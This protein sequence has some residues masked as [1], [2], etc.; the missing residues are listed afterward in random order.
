MPLFVC[1]VMNIVLYFSFHKFKER[2]LKCKKSLTK[3]I[4]VESIKKQQKSYNSFQA[5]K[6]VK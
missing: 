2:F 5:K 1:H 3:F 6:E 4:E